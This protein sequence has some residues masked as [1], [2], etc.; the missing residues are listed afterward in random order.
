[1]VRSPVIRTPPGPALVIVSETVTG[2]LMVML[3]LVVVRV[4]VM[5]APA[6]SV[7]WLGAVPVTT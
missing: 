4:L 2:E 1:M 6:A 7:S 5:S 3:L